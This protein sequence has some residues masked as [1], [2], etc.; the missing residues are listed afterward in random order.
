MA[1]H[2]SLYE[3][4][5][6]LAERLAQYLRSLERLGELPP[7]EG[8]WRPWKPA[9][10]PWPA[11]A[12]DGSVNRIY[13]RGVWVFALGGY[14][15]YTGS[16]TGEV[17]YWELD[18]LPTARIEEE[19]GLDLFLK[20]GMNIAELKALLAAAQKL[21]GGLVLVD[22]AIR[23]LFIHIWR[24][25]PKASLGWFNP[26]VPKDSREELHPRMVEWALSA[27]EAVA[28][29]LM[30]R[31]VAAWDAPVLDQELDLALRFYTMHV[32]YAELVNLLVGLAR[33]RTVVA[34]SKTTRESDIVSRLG[35]RDLIGDDILYLTL[36][37]Y[38]AGYTEPRVIEPNQFKGEHQPPQEIREVPVPP[39]TY[40]Y[41]RLEPGRPVYRIEVPVQDVD[42]EELL[43]TLNSLAVEGYP[44]PLM[45]A[46]SQ[47]SLGHRDMERLVG[48]AGLV[49]GHPGRWP[50]GS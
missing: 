15:F 2:H 11:A 29:G 5:P 38:S 25:P 21:D 39:I 44:Y 40:F 47:V 17:A 12:S 8:I 28:P 30:E 3:K 10:R 19:D 18:F 14:G 41:A 27:W 9:E 34:V 45:K 49:A 35:L 16:E 20:F 48:L 1:V 43:A 26:P 32:E 31:A 50:L 37:T 36:K 42:P 22:G 23:S 13:A 6:R 33:E 46:H 24:N 7:P 4:L